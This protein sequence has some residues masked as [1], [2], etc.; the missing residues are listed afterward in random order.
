KAVTGIRRAL[1]TGIEV[2]VSCCINERNYSN[3]V[4]IAEEMRKIGVRK[5]VFGHLNYTDG[6]PKD[7]DVAKLWLQIERLKLV[8]GMSFLPDLLTHELHHWYCSPNT[9]IRPEQKCRVAWH[10]PRIMPDGDVRVAF[11]CFNQESMGNAFE[12]DLMNVWQG[13]KY[14][15]FRKWIGRVGSVKE[16][17]RCCSLYGK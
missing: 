8:K 2:G 11:R 12:D 15:E 4:E 3:L 14:Q 9:N 17:Y 5:M 6:K 7:V 1:N 13:E 16:C 10:G